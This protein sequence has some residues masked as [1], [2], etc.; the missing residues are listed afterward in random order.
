MLK[1]DLRAAHLAVGS[2]RIHYGWV[3]V[4]IAT[5]MLLVTSSVRFAP[6]ALVPY[7]NDPVV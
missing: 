3:I 6:A 2:Q 7:L 5:I 4:A 1:V